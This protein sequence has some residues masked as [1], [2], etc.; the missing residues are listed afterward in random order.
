MCKKAFV[1]TLAAVMICGML[2][3]GCGKEPALPN[4]D[5]DGSTLSGKVEYINGRTCLLRIIMEDSHYD[6]ED[7]VYLTYSSISGDK[8]ISVGDEVSFSYHYATDVAEYNGE[9][10]ITVNE[11]SVK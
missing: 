8:A 9:P 10:S 5:L 4:I 7:L 6:Q 2:L 3:S 1:L 11:V